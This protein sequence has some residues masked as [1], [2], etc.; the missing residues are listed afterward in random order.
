MLRLV[1]EIVRP[2]AVVWDVGANV[3]LFTFAAASVVG[4]RGRVLAVEPDSLLVRLL[5]RSATLNSR[6]STVDV[7]PAA[8]SDRVGIGRFHIGRRNR[9]TNF[10]EGFGTTQ[11]GGTRAVELVPTVTLDWLAGHFPLP[12]VI[13]IDVE[14]A[15][16]LVLR[17]AGSVLDAHPALICE[18]DESNAEQ[19]RKLLHARGY[20]IYDGEL[21]A[22]KRRPVDTAPP[23]LLALPPGSS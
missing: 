19:V 14:V 18:V 22:S 12:D 10:L 17:G 13:K 21:S 15:E 4:A 8:V 1:T 7:L 3:G 2:G 6:L 5:R 23:A 9:S 16:L 11:T 20:L